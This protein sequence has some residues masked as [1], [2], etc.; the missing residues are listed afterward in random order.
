[1]TDTQAQ[2]REGLA[3]F[4]RVT[5][6]ADTLAS[7]VPITAASRAHI[8]AAYTELHRR[9]ALTPQPDTEGMV[10]VPREPTERMIEAGWEAGKSIPR[11]WVKELWSAMLAA[12]PPTPTGIAPMQDGGDEG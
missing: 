8:D 3:I 2:G 11:V 12:A 7:D 6:L 1:M 4:E 10:L 9:A 5:R